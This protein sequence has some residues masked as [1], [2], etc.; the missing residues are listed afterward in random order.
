MWACRARLATFERLQMHVLIRLKKH[1]RSRCIPCHV[2]D[3]SSERLCTLI[4]MYGHDQ[5]LDTFSVLQAHAKSCACVHDCLQTLHSPD[6][7]YLKACAVG[8]DSGAWHSNASILSS[9]NLMSHS[10]HCALTASLCTTNSTD[11]KVTVRN[12][13]WPRAIKINTFI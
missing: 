4:K 9:V 3:V 1:V 5:N 2:C 7:S 6:D 12:E 11:M 13:R 8:F 10:K